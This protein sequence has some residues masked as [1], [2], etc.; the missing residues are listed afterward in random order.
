M[1]SQDCSIPSC[2]LRHVYGK[3]SMLCT[4]RPTPAV[5]MT[6][7]RATNCQK[8]PSR[9]T[10]RTPNL[11]AEVAI[12]YGKRVVSCRVMSSDLLVA[13]KRMPSKAGQCHKTLYESH[14]E[15]RQQVGFPT[16]KST[17]TDY[18]GKL[19]NGFQDWL[20]QILGWW[21]DRVHLRWLRS[22]GSRVGRPRCFE[23]G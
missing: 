6:M 13:H 20:S 1:S 8:I 12:M 22:A 10:S 17:I 9:T 11:T 3:S 18:C 2:I 23:S 16:W 7:S 15:A 5:A 21:S 19:V 4:T 14:A